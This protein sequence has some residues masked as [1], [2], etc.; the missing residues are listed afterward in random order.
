MAEDVFALFDDYAAR[1]AR[2]ERPDARAYLARAGER[3]DELATLLDRYLESAPAASPDAES[4]RVAEAWLA[5]D[6]PLVALRSS[7]GIRVEHVVDA[8]MDRL[9]LDP[10]KRAKVKRY[11]QR[12]EQGLLEPR[13]VSGRVWDVLQTTLGAGVERAAAWRPRPLAVDAAYLR[14]DAL[15]QAHVPPPAAPAA[16]LDEIDELFLSGRDATVGSS[17]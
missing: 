12:L 11:Y 14:A 10:S 16:D 6:P 3:A 1:F 7:R 4:V 2:G 9:A 8:L 15:M 13:G 17:E 5:G